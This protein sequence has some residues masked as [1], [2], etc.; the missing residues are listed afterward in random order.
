MQSQGN[1]DYT[2]LSEL[3][4]YLRDITDLTHLTNLTQLRL[5]DNPVTNPEVLQPL[6]DG[7]TYIDILN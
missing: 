4:C 3:N 1:A 5:A 2:K 6:A 7:G